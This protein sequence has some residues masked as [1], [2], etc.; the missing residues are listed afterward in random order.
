MSARL[1][2]VIVF[3]RGYA[4]AA[5][6]IKVGC[7]PF[8][9]RPHG[10]PIPARQDGLDRRLAAYK[11]REC[12]VHPLDEQEDAA[13]TA[14]SLTRSSLA[15]PIWLPKQ[16]RRAR[17][18]L[19]KHV[20]IS[21][22]RIDATLPFKGSQLTLR[23]LDPGRCRIL[24]DIAGEPAL[25]DDRDLGDAVLVDR[26]DRLLQAFALKRPVT[27]RPPTSITKSI[28]LTPFGTA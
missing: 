19:N 7:L 27:F 1:V 9:A 10:Y 15:P 25:H 18:S 12:G 14:S 26:R 5:A 23:D 16:G 28:W 4:P 2:A 8:S 6:V 17:R 20:N 3:Y 24:E 13:R 11:N 22:Q 21:N